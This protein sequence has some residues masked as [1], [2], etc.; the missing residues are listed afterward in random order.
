MHRNWCPILRRLWLGAGSF[1]RLGCVGD[2]LKRGNW[3]E[4]PQKVSCLSEQHQRSRHRKDEK[5][6]SAYPYGSSIPLLLCRMGSSRCSS[7]LY[8]KSSVNQSSWHSSRWRKSGVRLNHNIV[9][10]YQSCLPRS[11]RLQWWGKQTFCRLY[12]WLRALRHCGKKRSGR[13]VF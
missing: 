10:V 13:N 3:S 8:L 12:R 2:R 1:H 11:G 6:Q 5:R 4:K 9:A 7:H